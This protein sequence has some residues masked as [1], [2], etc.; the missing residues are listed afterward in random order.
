MFGEGWWNAFRCGESWLDLRD[1]SIAIE[2]DVIRTSSKQHTSKCRDVLFGGR[3]I[4][5]VDG[6]NVGVG[7]ALGLG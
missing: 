6:H 5:K 7:L 1:G 3:Q 2:S 4:A